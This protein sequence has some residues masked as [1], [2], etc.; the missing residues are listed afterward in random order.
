MEMLVLCIGFWRVNIN[1]IQ[2]QLKRKRHRKRVNEA[3]TAEFASHLECKLNFEQNDSEPE[4]ILRIDRATQ[5][6]FGLETIMHGEC[7]DSH[8]YG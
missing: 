7:L 3:E 5:A 8:G 1:D 2:W 4:R 6:F